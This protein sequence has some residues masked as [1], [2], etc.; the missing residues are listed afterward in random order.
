MQNLNLKIFKLNT[1]IKRLNLIK[2][3]ILKIY[4]KNIREI[5]DYFFKFFPL[6]L[7]NTSYGI[8]QTTKFLINY[9]TKIF[10][11]FL[12]KNFNFFKIYKNINIKNY[13]KVIFILLLSLFF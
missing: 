11:Y 2:D 6:A 4:K 9:F 1:L 13:K 10:K 7:K 5:Q 8:K 12:N 3:Y